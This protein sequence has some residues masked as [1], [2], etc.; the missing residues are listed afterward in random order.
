MTLPGRL[1]L[2][3]SVADRPAN[4]L[5][6]AIMSTWVR[7][8]S[9]IAAWNSGSLLLAS[10]PRGST[11]LRVRFGW[12]VHAITDSRDSALNMQRAGLVWGIITG[13]S[14]TIGS[15]V[16]NPASSGADPSPPLSRWIWYELRSLWCTAYDSDGHYQSWRDTGTQEV[17]DSK[18]E[19]IAN[20]PSGQT[21]DVFASWGTVDPPALAGESSL[22]IW[23]SVLHS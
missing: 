16:P 13:A 19:V 14:G 2:A 3:D 7:Q 20:V 10:V 6:G 1:S 18:A 5:V 23:S 4:M 9:I 11:L 12:G 17:T 22:W 21:L 8:A 15:A